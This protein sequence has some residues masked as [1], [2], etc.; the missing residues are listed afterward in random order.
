MYLHVS[1]V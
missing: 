1:P